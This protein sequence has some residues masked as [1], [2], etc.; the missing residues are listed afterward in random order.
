LRL[1][2]KGVPKR[3]NGRGDLFVTL[4]IVLPDDPDPRLAAFMK[5]WSEANRQDPRKSMGVAP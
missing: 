4:K 3:G 1:K 2:G 5:E